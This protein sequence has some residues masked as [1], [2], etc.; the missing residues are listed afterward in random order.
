MKMVINSL[1]VNV[2][3]DPENTPILFIHGFP[4]DYTLWESQINHLK[5][6]YYCIA[7]DVR[8]LGDSYV[9]DGQYTMEA[10]VDDAFSIVHEM[11]LDRPVLCGLSMGGY[12]ALRTAERDPL[13]FRGL[14][15]CNTKADA[16]DN[17]AKIKRAKQIDSINVKGLN[18]FIDE[19]IPQ[20]FASKTIDKNRTLVEKTITAS[21]KHIPK[22]VKGAIFAIMSRTD[23]TEFLKN[24]QI[25][26]LVI[27]GS[28]DAV[29]PADKMKELASLIKNSEFV[30]IPDSGH[31]TA[32]ENPDAVNKAIS[33]FLADKVK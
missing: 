8:G 16:D 25:P 11:N 2:F 12:V 29:T 15:L 1:S 3:G 32:I 6:D 21:K 5:K 13:R 31:L 20:C 33:G 26:S 14:I 10:Y 4:F 18:R 7:Y 19:F 22:G 17:N 28:A 23:T 24:C 27:A 30:T 9:G